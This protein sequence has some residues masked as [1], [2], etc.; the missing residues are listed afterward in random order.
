VQMA[1]P[2]GRHGSLEI[3]LEALGQE[4]ELK[5]ISLIGKP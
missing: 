2:P 3:L 1:V 5:R 4:L